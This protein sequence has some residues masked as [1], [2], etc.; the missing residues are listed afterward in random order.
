MLKIPAKTLTISV[1][2]TSI[3]KK[4]ISKLCLYSIVIWYLV[5]FVACQSEEKEPINNNEPSI[6][7]WL[8]EEEVINLELRGDLSHLLKE[9]HTEDHYHPAQI[10]LERGESQLKLDIEIARRGVTRKRI[11][12]FPP[13]KLK[14]PKK[15]LREHGFSEFTTYK[16]VTHCLEFEKELVL[17][18]Y[19]VYKLFNQL[20]DKSFKVQLA[21][22]KYFD[23]SQ[24][25]HSNHT[26]FG[27]LIESNKELANRLEGKLV[28]PEKRKITTVDK[29][30]YKNMVLFQYMIGNTDWNI[31]K[32]HNIKWVQTAALNAPTPIPYD[33]DYC[34]LVDAPYAVPHPQLP[35]K[36]VRERLLQW[37]GKSTE[38]LLPICEE[39]KTKKDHFIQLCNEIEDLDADTKKDVIAF[40]E[41]FF[42][43][44]EDGIFL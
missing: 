34:G 21:N 24:N 3:G 36:N 4:E 7:E 2:L 40:I 5:L 38:E 31:T 6:F 33:F 37:R 41:T 11:C 16:L 22:T 18:E 20:T 25:L 42:K 19:L 17:K 15:V 27:F 30:Q 1:S 29:E 8:N 9:S 12:D 28:N 13:I 14:F 10:F 44:V 26:H 35:I 43:E 32:G 23:D 39:F